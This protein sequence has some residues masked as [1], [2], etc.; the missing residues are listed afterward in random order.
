VKG[1]AHTHTQTCV[2]HWT[3]DIG[4]ASDFIFCPMLLYIALDRQ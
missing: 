3:S 4:H 1:H 2:A